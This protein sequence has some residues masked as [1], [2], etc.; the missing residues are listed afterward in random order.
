MNR[1]TK[2]EYL[3]YVKN[4]KPD[5]ELTTRP[6][7]FEKW[8]VVQPIVDK[9]LG[10]SNKIIKNNVSQRNNSLMQSRIKVQS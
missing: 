5:K 10:K 2:K 8:K 7:T 3:E 6:T 4:F 1:Y 9:I